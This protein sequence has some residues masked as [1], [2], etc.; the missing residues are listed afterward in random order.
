M[1][2]TAKC[3]N[4][5]VIERC[6]IDFSL[7]QVGVGVSG[8][9]EAAVSS[10]RRVVDLLDN[11][12]LPHILTLWIFIISYSLAPT[13]SGCSSPVVVTLTPVAFT[14]QITEIMFRFHLNCLAS[15]ESFASYWVFPCRQIWAW[16]NM[17]ITFCTF[18]T[19]KRT[20]SHNWKARITIGI[21][22]KCF[23]CYNSC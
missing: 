12:I 17:L 6:S 8:V 21:I 14:G 5:H 18:A 11:H 3:A 23:W 20:C 10:I 2:Q 9:A 22:T 15:K 1:L 13:F 16:E 19:R 4:C 7:I